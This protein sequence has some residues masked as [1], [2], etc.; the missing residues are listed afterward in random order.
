[1]VISMTLTTF[2]VISRGFT[3]SNFQRKPKNVVDPKQTVVSWT[4]AATRSRNNTRLLHNDD[5]GQFKEVKHLP[6]VS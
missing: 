3:C 2:E 6:S 5:N 1:M 4:M